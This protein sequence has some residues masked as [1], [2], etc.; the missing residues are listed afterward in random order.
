MWAVLGAAGALVVLSRWLPSDAARQ[1]A[2]SRGGPV[3]GFL[4]AVTVLAGLADRAGVFDVAAGACARA[5]RGSTLRLFLLT[6]ALGTAT[7]IGM[8]LDTTAVLLTPVV[9]TV[10]DQLELSPLPFAFLAVWLAN[11]ASL[12]LPVSN[13]TNL[14]AVQRV[15]LS[16]VG[17]AARMA[18]PELVAVTVTVAYIGLVYR[19]DIT[20][21]Y[22]PPRR[23][24]V[25]DPWTFRVCAV[26]CLAVAPGVIGGVPPWAVATPCATAAVAVFAVRQRTQLRWSLLPW[27]IVIFTE[28][29]FL[30]VTAVARHG[31]TRL[32]TELSG[33]SVLATTTTAVAASN[34]V[35][36]LPSYLA[37]E[38]AVPAGRTTQLLGGIVG[39]NAGP[40]ILVWGSL[41]TILWRDRC[42]AR[43]V[44]IT[45]RTFA[46]IGLGGVPS[47]SWAPGPPSS[48]PD[49]P[50][51][52]PLLKSLL[53]LITPMLLGQTA[54][55][56]PAV[57]S[58][59]PL[60]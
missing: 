24:R 21:S 2:I 44:R 53:R 35:N 29:L 47:S 25:D 3:M 11:T 51:R 52:Q 15:G 54:R 22:D 41:A 4:L 55:V 59:R 18:L 45:L 26:A 56:D 14:L 7:T 1:V 50:G 42:A 48:S 30:V 12:L 33:H 57:S 34:L 6:A 20:G 39:T 16:T 38:T 5:A 23:R 31:G 9:L 37:I 13:L 49:D 43:G 28:G 36:N 27:R 60:C 58:R 17:F 32:L 8:S 10:A 46:A 40:L 19:H